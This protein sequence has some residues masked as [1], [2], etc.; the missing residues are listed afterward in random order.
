MP[1]N[2]K[3]ANEKPEQM[4]HPSD[5]LAPAEVEEEVRI[6]LEK[7]RQEVKQIAKLE[8]AG[9]KI[10]QDLLHVRMRKSNEP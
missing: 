10:S 3:R 1:D 4:P 9:E 7:A 2:S 8:R 5:K 6:L